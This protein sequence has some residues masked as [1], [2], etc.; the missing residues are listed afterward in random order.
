MR[1]FNNTDMPVDFRDRVIMPG[2]SLDMP[3]VTDQQLTP[4]ERRA[5]KVGALGP[6]AGKT[7]KVRERVKSSSKSSVLPLSRLIALF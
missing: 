3:S 7:L 1:V 2:M 6:A 5:F 4:D